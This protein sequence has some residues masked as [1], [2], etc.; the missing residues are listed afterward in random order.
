MFLLVRDDAHIG[1]LQR[2]RGR[3]SISG[4]APAG[5]A[6]NA[7]VV[8]GRLPFGWQADGLHLGAIQ[9]EGSVA[10]HANEGNVVGKTATHSRPL[11]MLKLDV[12]VKKK[13][14]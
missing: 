13:T 9:V 8:K 12:W 3:P 7:G 4:E 11:G 2:P 5:D 1:E 10:G 14:F 6:G